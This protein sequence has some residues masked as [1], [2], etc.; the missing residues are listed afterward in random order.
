MKTIILILISTFIYIS[1]YSQ[2]EE[3]K[4]YLAEE[5]LYD[6][7]FEFALKLYQEMLVKSPNDYEINFKIGF[8]YLNIHNQKDKALPYLEK[9]LEK[10]SKKLKKIITPVEIYYYMARAYHLTE[11]YEKVLEYLQKSSELV[12]DYKTPQA[13][14][15]IQHE[16]TMCKNAILYSQNPQDVNIENINTNINSIYNEISPVLFDNYT[17]ML[18]ASDYDNDPNDEIY[19]YNKNIYK[20]KKSK[21]WKIFTFVEEFIN[22]D[23]NKYICDISKDGKYLIIN[24]EDKLYI[25]KIEEKTFGTTQ[26]INE[27]I[28]SKQSEFSACFAFEDNA[29]IFSSNRKK[30]YGGKDLYISTKNNNGAWSKPINMGDKINSKLDEDCPYF[31]HNKTLYFSSNGEKSMGGY[32]IVYTKLTPDSTWEEIIN[33]GY[34]TNSVE[35]DMYFSI[36]RDANT[37]YYASNR[38]GTFGKFDILK[39]QL[40]PQKNNNFV[41]EGNFVTENNKSINVYDGNTTKFVRQENINTNKYFL[42]LEKN[43]NYVVCYKSENYYPIIKNFSIETTEN[44]SIFYHPTL[45]PT[46]QTTNYNL[47]IVNNKLNNLSNITLQEIKKI[48]NKNVSF[49]IYYNPNNYELSQ[50]ISTELVESSFEHTNIKLISDPKYLDNINIKISSPSINEEMSKNTSS[51]ETYTIQIGAFVLP[52]SNKNFKNVNN[53]TIFKGNDKIS[54]VTYGE[55]KT[56][57]EA[58]KELHKLINLGYKQAFTRPLSF[59]NNK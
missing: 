42:N 5:S 19:F 55:Y 46:S 11:D 16:I 21:T 39:I 36:N 54:R 7:N 2:T 20:S 31:S 45:I 27:E 1:T 51:I 35:E 3:D 15:I 6:E 37:G 29:I 47:E 32:D 49:E 53:V 56:V 44:D 28:N 24:I 18:F 17:Q 23:N 33:M 10:Y 14:P 40:K 43:I 22:I 26:I 41:I 57:T 52:V 30:G 34:P 9:A 59:Y 25:S 8:C 50:Q 58:E 13:I 4:Y 12:D 48:N 38:T